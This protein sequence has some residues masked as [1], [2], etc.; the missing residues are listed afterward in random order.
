MSSGTSGKESESVCLVQA[1]LRWTT[2]WNPVSHMFLPQARK[3]FGAHGRNTLPCPKGRS[4]IWAS[5]TDSTEVGIC[6]ACGSNNGWNPRNTCG[7]LAQSQMCNSSSHSSMKLIKKTGFG[8]QKYT[9]T[10]WHRYEWVCRFFVWSLLTTLYHCQTQNK[11]L[12]LEHWAKLSSKMSILAFFNHQ[13]TNAH[14]GQ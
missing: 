10:E 4:N 7:P 6:V 5:W 13:S 12:Y 9:F 8:G 11:H 14:A 1:G 2:V 3:D